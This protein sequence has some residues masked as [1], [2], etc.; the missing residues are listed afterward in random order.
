MAT[1]SF[2]NNKRLLVRK[3][4][5]FTEA[6]DSLEKTTGKFI[7]ID[8]LKKECMKL[9]KVMDI[10]FDNQ[11]FRYFDNEIM[12]AGYTFHPKKDFV[13]RVSTFQQN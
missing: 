1:K 11:D 2:L 7:P 10:K 13:Q 8:D 3:T 6:C 12:M 4:L 5:I 9:A